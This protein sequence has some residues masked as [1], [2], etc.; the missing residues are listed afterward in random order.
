MIAYGGALVNGISG[1]LTWS[2]ADGLYLSNIAIHTPGAVT[3]ASSI[4]SAATGLGTPAIGSSTQPVYWTGSAFAA[5]T[6][7]LPSVTSADAG[8]ILTVDS[9]G[10]WVAATM[11]QWTG[12]NY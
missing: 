11:A 5:T 3:Y 2:S 6:N 9:N 8:K 10:N 4:V 12:G 1:T 7:S